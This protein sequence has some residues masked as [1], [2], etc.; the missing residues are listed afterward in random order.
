MV[1][2]MLMNLS[3]VWNIPCN[4]KHITHHRST[5]TIDHT[6]NLDACKDHWKEDTN[7][8]NIVTLL[9]VDHVDV[10]TIDRSQFIKNPMI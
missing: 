10:A 9:W 3:S 2:D 1:V 5:N 7:S 6:C 8:I 4:R